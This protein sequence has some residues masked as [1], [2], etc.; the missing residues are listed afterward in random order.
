MQTTVR[1]WGNSFGFRIPSA[2]AKQMKLVE[3]SPIEITKTQNGM[4]IKPHRKRKTLSEMLKKIDAGHFPEL[5]SW[6]AN[7]GKEAW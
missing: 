7:S 6:G 2:F 3:G 1:K 5:V 4:L